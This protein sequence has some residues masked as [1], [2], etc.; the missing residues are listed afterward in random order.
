MS[1][2]L[3]AH[4]F[5][6][7][8][9][10]CLVL[11]LGSGL[12][13][14][15]AT[16]QPL[17]M[18]HTQGPALLNAQNQ[19]VVLR[20]VN[21]GGW[22]LQESYILRTDSL[23]AQWRIQ[24]GLLRTMPEAA[25]EDFYRRYRAGFITKADID[26]IAR[27]GFNCVRLPFHYDLFLSTAQRRARTRAL[28][29]PR[30][31]EAYVQA[32]STWYD[33]N[34]LFEDA[35]NLE[36]FRLI[37]DVLGWCAAN[38]LYVVLDLHAAPG[39][40][41]ADRNISDCLVPLD[42]WKRRDAQGRLIYQ[43]L[44]VRL[45]QKLSARYKNDPRVALYDF[46]NEPNGMTTANGL[47]GDNSELSA[48]YSRLIDVVRAQNDQHV[49]LLEG[50]GYGNEYTNLTPDKLRTVHKGNLMYNAHRYWCPNDAAASD[51]NPLQINLI[52][53]LAAFRDQWQVPVWVGETGE[54]SNEWFAAAVQELNQQNIGWCHWTL[55]RVD[56]RTSLLNVARYGSLLT[57][58]GRAALL[59]NSEFR[60]CTVNT[61]VVAALT[62]PTAPPAAFVPHILP[63]TIQ[64]ADYDLGRLGRA[65]ADTYA[66][67]TDYRNSAP[68]NSGDAYRNDG[69]DVEAVADAASNGFAVSH[70]EAGEWLNY[71]VTV[72]QA[73]TCAIQVRLQ[74]PAVTPARL[75]LKL[76]D[77]QQLIGAVAVP[78]G[79]GWQTLP[80]GTA[81]LPAG[82]HTIRLHV[83]QPGAVV[84]WLRFD[85]V[86]GPN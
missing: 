82:T 22:L 66:T 84:S 24:Q 4:R 12:L 23:N 35:E 17:S 57:A 72:P 76:D 77:G 61:D 36:G 58:A 25:V 9:A 39:G 53:N 59:R 32:L 45:W 8:L 62:R 86:I 33:R 26:F 38:N 29:H 52:C 40:Q 5:C 31:I 83:E 75:L 10:Y 68:H 48:L 20:G 3:R 28:Q 2:L 67:R 63:G 70:M 55:K 16:A 80:A 51:P 42:L 85:P 54:N 15:T 81:R 47:A 13:R 46:I 43:D 34:Q 64:V 37:D 73:T 11:L 6:G 71:T 18:L 60:H 27:Q 41:G 14:S 19:P 50:N 74:N 30:N 1:Q 21:L 7:Q 44:T 49:V 79:A 56:G 65:Y 78:G 69:V